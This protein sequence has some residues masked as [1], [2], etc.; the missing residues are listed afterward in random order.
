MF[1]RFIITLKPCLFH[2]YGTRT[3]MDRQ[4]PHEPNCFGFFSNLQ[5]KHLKHQNITPQ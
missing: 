3:V 2:L 4:I 1:L 5:E